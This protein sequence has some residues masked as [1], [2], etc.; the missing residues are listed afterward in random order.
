MCPRTV[1]GRPWVAWGSLEREG[2]EKR[3]LRSKPCHSERDG[4]PEDGQRRTRGKRRGPGL[5]AVMPGQEV[6]LIPSRA[7]TGDACSILPDGKEH[8]EDQ[9]DGPEGTATLTVRSLLPTQGP[10]FS[11]LSPRP[12]LQTS[13]DLVQPVS[14]P[15]HLHKRETFSREIRFPSRE[16][17]P[18][19]C[20]HCPSLLF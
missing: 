16:L 17:D 9:G 19:Q 5:M 20:I 11:G 18:F 10:R 14:C 6:S 15:T 13:R 3:A 8:L 7:Q 2:G 4:R 1:I 12:P